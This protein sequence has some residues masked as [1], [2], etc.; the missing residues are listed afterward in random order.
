[1][2]N[3][4]FLLVSSQNNRLITSHPGARGLI[5]KPKS[6]RYLLKSS[7]VIT[8]AEFAPSIFPVQLSKEQN[9]FRYE[10]QLKM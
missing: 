9:L 7:S 8:M 5:P 2:A 1:M 10:N 3:A 6:P 4:G